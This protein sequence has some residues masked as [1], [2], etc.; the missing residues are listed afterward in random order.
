MD[1]KRTVKVISAGNTYFFEP[2][3]EGQVSAIILAQKL[4]G[5]KLIDTAGV[6]LRK[7]GGDEQWTNI[8]DA[9]AAEDMSARDFSILLRDAINGGTPNSEPTPADGE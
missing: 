8:V 2:I 1:D 3:S 5:T 4:G 7:R 9:M 6:V